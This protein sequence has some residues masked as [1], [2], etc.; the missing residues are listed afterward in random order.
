AVVLVVGLGCCF[1][2]GYCADHAHG[3]VERCARKANEDVVQELEE[4]RSLAQNG[5]DP[6]TSQPFAS[7]TRLLK[8]FLSRQIPT[9]DEALVGL[10][11]GRLVGLPGPTG[12]SLAE[13][14]PLI[15]HAIESPMPAGLY[16]PDDG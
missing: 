9:R 11:D 4:F 6:E 8:V 3:A 1:A 13:G 12:R 10:V 14:D 5:V 2:V 16:I 15:Q 7:N